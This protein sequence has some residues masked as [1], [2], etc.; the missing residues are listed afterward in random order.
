LAQ[1]IIDLAQNEN[2][3]YKIGAMARQFSSKFDFDV[4]IEQLERPRRGYM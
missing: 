1:T 4:Q 2:F 3:S